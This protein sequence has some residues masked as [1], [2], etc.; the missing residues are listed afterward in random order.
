MIVLDEFP[1][2]ADGLGRV[3]GV[4]DVEVADRSATDSTAV[5]DVLEYAFAP[6]ATAA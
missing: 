1:R 4:V 5:V 3:V 6:R 2:L